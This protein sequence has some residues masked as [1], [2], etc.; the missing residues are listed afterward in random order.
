M[1]KAYQLYQMVGQLLAEMP[2]TGESEHYDQATYGL[3]MALDA[4]VRVDDPEFK[5]TSFP[6]W[7]VEI[8]KEPKLRGVYQS[9]KSADYTVRQF[10]D[11]ATKYQGWVVMKKDVEVDE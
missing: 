11:T 9:E 8:D 6:V 10:K 4:L 5:G 1:T 7:V 3:V 2:D